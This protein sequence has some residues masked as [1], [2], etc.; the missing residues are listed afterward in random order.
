MEVGGETVRI[1]GFIDRMGKQGW[2][3]VSVVPE[4]MAGGVTR[5]F[6]YWFKRP[7]P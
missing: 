3:L 1:D 5:W 2:E 4:T 6:L 7:K